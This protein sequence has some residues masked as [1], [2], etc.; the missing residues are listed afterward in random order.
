VAGVDSGLA[1][2]WD[3]YEPDDREAMLGR[4]AELSGRREPAG[5]APERLFTELERRFASRDPDS[6]LELYAED[7]ALIDHRA[8][9]WEEVRGRDAIGEV[10]RHSLATQPNVELEIDEVLACDDR[11]IVLCLTWRGRGV[12]A[13]ELAYTVGQVNVVENG[14]WLSTE[15][16]EPE[17]R[18]AMIARFAELGGGQAA[19]GDRPPERFWAEFCQRWATMDADRIA[20]LYA[21]DWVGIEHRQLGWEEMRGREAVRAYI[22]SVLEDALDVRCEVEEVLAC[23]ERAIAL[24]VTYGG[25]STRI[26]RGTWQNGY[27]SVVLVD[28][29]QITRLE[30]FEPDERDAML[31]CYFALGGT[32]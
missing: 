30:R 32:R 2:S 6:V 10:L 26:G 14:R 25:S 9:G 19:L 28:A 5:R 8:L 13:G 16:F 18:Q 11:V 27:G 7:Y 24:I 17:D 31:A 29:N 22:A 12:K 23:D 21:D 3:L 20:E 15:N 4:F 1:V